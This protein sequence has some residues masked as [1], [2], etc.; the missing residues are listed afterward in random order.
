MGGTL[1]TVAQIWYFGAM[2]GFA[3]WKL[4]SLLVVV[5]GIA[6]D[7]SMSALKRWRKVKDMGSILPGVGGLLDRT[8]SL[9]LV[10]PACY[11]V[12]V[13]HITSIE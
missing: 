2:Y 13:R 10:L 5:F 6:G 7:L 11:A 8:D 1:A 3:D 12:D 4:T 9:L